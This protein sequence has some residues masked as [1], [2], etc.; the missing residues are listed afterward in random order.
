MLFRSLA[1]P[2]RLAPARSFTMRVTVPGLERASSLAAIEVS[3]GG[4]PFAEAAPSPTGI[5]ALALPAGDYTVS[6]R[7]A[8]DAREAG[9]A[10]DHV[11]VHLDRDLDVMIGDQIGASSGLASMRAAPPQHCPAR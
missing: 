10:M 11:A 2:L 4:C 6:A 1:L 9:W 7:M 8:T 3:A 5:T